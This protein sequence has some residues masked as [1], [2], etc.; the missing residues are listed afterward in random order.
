M[1]A[2]GRWRGDP[3]RR[4]GATWWRSWSSKPAWDSTKSQVGSIPI[5]LRQFRVACSNEFHSRRSIPPCAR[6]KGAISGPHSSSR[7][8]ARCLDCA[9]RAI[10]PASIPWAGM[11]RRRFSWSRR[12]PAAACNIQTRP[13][14]R[15][16]SWMEWP[17]LARRWIVGPKNRPI[18]SRPPGSSASMPPRKRTVRLEYTKLR[19]HGV[20]GLFPWNVLYPI[21]LNGSRP[22][23]VG[24]CRVGVRGCR[25]VFWPCGW[26]PRADG[27]TAFPVACSTVTRVRCRPSP[28]R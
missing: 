20:A 13:P 25:A 8:P 27:C 14:R 23:S 11:P 21:A 5:H 19:P 1:P 7:W 10:R 24:R 22:R 6:G 15:R 2:I 17:I 3:A 4:C 16:P 12:S 26:R 9:A 28:A 18:S